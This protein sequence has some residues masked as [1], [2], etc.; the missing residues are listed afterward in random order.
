MSLHHPTHASAT[1]S[2]S[3]REVVPKEIVE[4][5]KRALAVLESFLDDD[6]EERRE[7]SEYLQKALDED[8]PP[9]FRHFS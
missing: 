1:I 7:T 5:N 3:E 4:R 2:E 8:R 9:G 6:P